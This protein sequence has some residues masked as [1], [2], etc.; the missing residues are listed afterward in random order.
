MQ[1]PLRNHKNKQ[2]SSLR[3]KTTPWVS[4]HHH[5][6]HLAWSCS[7]IRP[8]ALNSVIIHSNIRHLPQVSD[9]LKHWE[10]WTINPQR[11]PTHLLSPYSLVSAVFMHGNEAIILSPQMFSQMRGAW[12]PQQSLIKAPCTRG[13]SIKSSS[14]TGDNE[15]LQIRLSSLSVSSNG[16]TTFTKAWWGPCVILWV[17][18]LCLWL[19]GHRYVCLCASQ[20][21]KKA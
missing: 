3:Y 16:G 19:E 18:S 14:T 11:K 12:L 8:A 15:A 13:A 10:T 6:H 9:S 1:P 20:E 17:R 5:H 21:S 4:V 2:S 7:R